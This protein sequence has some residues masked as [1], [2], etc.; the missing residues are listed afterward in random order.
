MDSGAEYSRRIPVNI[1]DILPNIRSDLY[2]FVNDERNE[3]TQFFRWAKSC[4]RIFPELALLYAIP[5]GLK[6]DGTRSEVGTRS[7]IPDI[8]LP[9]RSGSFSSLYIEMKVGDN[10]TSREQDAWLK[11]LHAAGNAVCVAYG[12]IQAAWFTV[13]YLTDPDDFVSGP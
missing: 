8:H 11:K 6:R 5:N 2:H 13:E 1:R 3:M 9:A 12:W 7:G 4:E 10:D